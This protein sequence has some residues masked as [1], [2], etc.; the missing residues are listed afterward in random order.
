[1]IRLDR[2]E[3][4]DLAGNVLL[5]NTP[6]SLYH[7]L[8]KTSAVHRMK[9]ECEPIELEGYYDRITVRARQTEIE[10]G[11]AYGVLVALLTSEKARSTVDVSRRATQSIIIR[12]SAVRPTLRN[13]QSP[14]GTGLF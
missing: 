1:M 6:Y 11:I 2:K 3:L 13:Q 5:A 10:L 7:A 8:V 14:G 12:A 9:E 4:L